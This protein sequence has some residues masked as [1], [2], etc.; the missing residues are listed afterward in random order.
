MEYSVICKMYRLR[1]ILFKKGYTGLN[2]YN[3]YTTDDY[4]KDDFRTLCILFVDN[5]HFNYLQIVSS[6]NENITETYEILESLINNN[7]KE[8]E[9]I[10]KKEYPI[11]IKWS[12]NIYN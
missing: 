4:N 11:S 8:W 5:N 9:K 3:I 2:V 1:I 7:L 10:R 6:H 12:P